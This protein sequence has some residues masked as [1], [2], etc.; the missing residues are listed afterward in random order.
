VNE[1]PVIARIALAAILFLIVAT[2]VIGVA[3]TS[4][5]AANK[6]VNELS[7]KVGYDSVAHL[8]GRKVDGP[9]VRVLARK[10]REYADTRL[11]TGEDWWVPDDPDDPDSYEGHIEYGYINLTY[12]P[13]SYAMISP[14]VAEQRMSAYFLAMY[15]DDGGRGHTYRISLRYVDGDVQGIDFLF[16]D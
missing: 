13:G 2:V 14:Q 6:E 7:A 15:G 8:D 3:N 9:A 11:Y 12:D 4:L 1:W 16:E 10:Y 5:M